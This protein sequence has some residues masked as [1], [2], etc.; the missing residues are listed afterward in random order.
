[1]V[2]PPLRHALNSSAAQKKKTSPARMA[3]PSVV[4]ATKQQQGRIRYAA[5]PC[6]PRRDQSSAG[7]VCIA[8]LIGNKRVPMVTQPR[9]LTP[10]RILQYVDQHFNE[11]ITPQDVA[12]AMHYSLCHLTHIARRTLGGSVSDLLLQRRIRA[13]QRLLA[14]ST[15]PVSMVAHQVGFTD[16]AYFSRRFSQATGASPSRWRRAHGTTPAARCHACGTVLPLV[17][18]AQD[19]AAHARA[20]AS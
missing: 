10:D 13:A 3:I 20:A 11:P 16:T 17:A 15:L 6:S 4:V 19:D 2:V 8:L 1:M 9:D 14:E 12:K 18:L 5:G 7:T